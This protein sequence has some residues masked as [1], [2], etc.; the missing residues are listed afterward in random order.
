MLVGEVGI[1]RR[2]FL[3][4][5]SWWEARRIMR[6]Y[7]RRD[8]ITKELLRLNAYCSLFS[9]AENKFNLTPS[10]WLTLPWEKEENEVNLTDEE[11]KEMQD[12]MAGMTI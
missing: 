3:Y 5:L 12:M 8:R 11:I 10:Q 4:E 7:T 1:P 9:T 6:G 2:E